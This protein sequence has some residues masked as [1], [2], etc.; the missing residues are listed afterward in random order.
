MLEEKIKV[1]GKENWESFSTRSPG[2]SRL[3]W[4]LRL[5][6]TVLL[7]GGV[8]ASPTLLL[9][10]KDLGGGTERALLDAACDM[11]RNVLEAS[12]K[13]EQTQ[14]LLRGGK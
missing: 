3:G 14:A 9:E 2:G 1:Q 5:Q 4:D 8:L 12:R 6:F 10:P 13:Q 7:E 11:I